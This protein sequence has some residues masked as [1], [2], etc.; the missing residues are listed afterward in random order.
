MSRRISTSPAS[1]TEKPPTHHEPESKNDFALN[2]ERHYARMILHSLHQ[3]CRTEA[4]V[5]GVAISPGRYGLSDGRVL[6]ILIG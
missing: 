5:A 3:A 1:K 2:I 6:Y 4:V